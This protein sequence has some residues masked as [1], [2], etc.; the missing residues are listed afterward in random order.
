MVLIEAV[1]NPLLRVFQSVVLDDSAR[2]VLPD[3]I[4]QGIDDE[5][6][7]VGVIAESYLISNRRLTLV[8]RFDESTSQVPGNLYVFYE[9][10]NR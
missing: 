9:T 3:D 8:D 10:L 7:G 6:T 1:S 2:L 5:F 4:F